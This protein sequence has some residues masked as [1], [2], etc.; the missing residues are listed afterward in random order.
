MKR[1]VTCLVL[2][3]LFALPISADTAEKFIFDNQ[4]SYVQWQVEHFGFS[5]QT[6]KWFVNGELTLDKENPQ[7]S[8][9]VATINLA[10]LITGLP[11]LDS[12][13]KDKQ[14]F[15]IAQFPIA[16][17]ESN[18]VELINS[19]TARVDGI[20]TLHGRSEPISLNVKL[21]RTGKNPVTNKMTV[22]FSAN[23]VLKRS[24]FGIKAYLPNI[25]DEVKIQIGAEAYQADA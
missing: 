16:K 1:I 2:N 13:L 19:S 20:L 22:G 12:E 11:K 6:G 5:N 3:L 14:F 15:N 24:D 23:T 25:G 10:D 8:K 7:N 9:V 18:R 17:F 4:H 21:N